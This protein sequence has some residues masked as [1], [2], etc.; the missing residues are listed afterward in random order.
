M[1]RKFYIEEIL[2][3]QNVP[4]FEPKKI[5]QLCKKLLVQLSKLHLTRPEGHFEDDKYF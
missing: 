4:K 2:Q 3:L 1:S 5:Q